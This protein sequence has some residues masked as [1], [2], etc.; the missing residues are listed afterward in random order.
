MGEVG[1]DPERHVAAHRV[2]IE[3]LTPDRETA[4]QAEAHAEARVAANGVDAE[5]VAADTETLSAAQEQLAA[6]ERRVRIYEQVMA[7]LDAAERATMK[8]A[9]RFLEQRMARDVDRITGGRYRRL[10]VDEAT[11]T[12]TVYSPELDDWVDVRRLSQGTLDQLYL[13]ARLGIV[14]QVTAPAS[15]PLVFDDPFVSFDDERAL[16]A[17]AMLHDMARE[18]QVLLLTTAIATT[19]TP[20]RCSS[21][22]LQPTRDESEPEPPAANAAVGRDDLDVEQRPGRAHRCHHAE[23]AL[24]VGPLFGLISALSW[25]TGDFCG[26]LVGRITSVLGAI[27]VSQSLGLLLATGLVVGTGEPVR[28]GPALLWAAVAGMSGRGRPGLLLLRLRARHDGRHRATGRPGGGGRA[29]DG[30]N[31]GR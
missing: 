31:R 25:G 5:Q 28:G 2:A 29:G 18:Y 22:L 15:P 9:A 13:C 19:V 14:R 6:A 24:T 20:T 23:G 21:C 8:K 12:F 11:L 30:R 17:V 1:R 10:K 7:T 26:G 16:R 3:R 4:L 27:L